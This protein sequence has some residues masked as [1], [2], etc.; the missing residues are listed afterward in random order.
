MK[1]ICP[2]IVV[3]DMERSRKFYE[4]LLGQTVKFDFGENVTFEGDFAIHLSTHFR[5]LIDGRPVKP[6]GNGYELY[7]EDDRVDE[8]A[9][10]LK[11][12]GVIFVHPVR[13]QPWRQKV[14]RFYDP[15]GHMVEVGESLEHLCFRLSQEGMS[16]EAIVQTIGLPEEF[17]RMG[18][19]EF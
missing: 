15:D 14:V 6:G 11:E 4:Q 2:L 5:Q 3:K 13:E 17:V 9:L 16:V 1:F 12:H 19:G 10:K 7:F 18:I 8:L